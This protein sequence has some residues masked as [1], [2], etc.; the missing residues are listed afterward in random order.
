M[1][2]KVGDYVKVINFSS[3]NRIGKIDSIDF[4]AARPEKSSFVR[5]ITIRNRVT[6]ESYIITSLKLATPL[7]IIKAKN[8]GL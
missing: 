1:D 2:F 8:N 4:A 5:I 7:E 3:D 6:T